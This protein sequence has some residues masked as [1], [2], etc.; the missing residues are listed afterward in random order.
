MIRKNAF[1]A[2]F[3]CLTQPLYPMLRKTLK[4]G[5]QAT[6]LARNAQRSAFSKN[7]LSQQQSIL[8]PQVRRY[9]Q[10]SNGAKKKPTFNKGRLALLA[11]TMF[12]IA[13]GPQLYEKRQI[14]VAKRGFSKRKPDYFWTL[15]IRCM[16][17]AKP[18]VAIEF[19]ESAKQNFFDLSQNDDGCRVLEEMIEAA[20][21]VAEKFTKPAKQ[22][23]GNLS[24]DRHGRGVVLAMIKA[25]PSLVTEFEIPAARNFVQLSTNFDG[26]QV[27][28]EMI[29]TRPSVAVEFVGSARQNFVQ[30]ANSRYG[31]IV[32]KEMIKASHYATA[33]FVEPAKQNF[34]ELAT[35][36]SGRCV[37]IKMIEAR[38]DVVTKFI[39]PAKQNFVELANSYY[40]EMVLKEMIKAKPSI[41]Q[42][43]LGG[44]CAK[45]LSKVPADLLAFIKKHQKCTKCWKAAK[46]GERIVT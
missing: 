36:Y 33:R 25:R 32:L 2:I 5:V 20:P 30:L 15:D 27:L 45:E 19:A 34:V 38:P 24:S 44:M 22:D 29:K 4:T 1:F 18:S 28:E 13:Y 8:K 23:F 31:S 9:A 40:G 3:I 17:K 11:G 46:Y 14:Y 12:A 43:L 10:P 39:A 21:V 26:V 41:T 16:I 37:L 6:M 42:E 7:S 35:D